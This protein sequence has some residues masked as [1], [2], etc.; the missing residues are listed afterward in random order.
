M[1]GE[2]MLGATENAAVAYLINP[3]NKSVVDMISKETYPEYY[4]KSE[5]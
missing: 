2:V 1:Y 5:K 3:S 4:K